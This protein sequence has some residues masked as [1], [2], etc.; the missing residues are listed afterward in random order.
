MMK[1]AFTQDFSKV[2]NNKGDDISKLASKYA[3]DIK[4]ERKNNMYYSKF[5]WPVYTVMDKV[6]VFA[7]GDKVECG[8]YYIHSEKFFLCVVMDGI[9]NQ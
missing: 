7:E 8:Y 4:R 3:Y 5:S 6:E 2:Y 9:V 1:W